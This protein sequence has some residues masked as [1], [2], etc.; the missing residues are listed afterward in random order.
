MLTNNRISERNNYLYQSPVRNI[1]KLQF[2]YSTAR[3]ALYQYLRS[4]AKVTVLTT[5]YVPQ[6]VYDPFLKLHFEIYYYDLD[7]SGN[8]DENDFWTIILNKFWIKN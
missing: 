4:K 2:L 5:S 7:A 3:Q 1:G 6:G 8:I